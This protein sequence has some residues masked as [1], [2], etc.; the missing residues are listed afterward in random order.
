[1]LAKIAR[2][3]IGHR[4]GVLAEERGVALASNQPRHL[5]MSEKNSIRV[6]DLVVQHILSLF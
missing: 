4:I 3:T 2:V 6:T 1:M 5:C